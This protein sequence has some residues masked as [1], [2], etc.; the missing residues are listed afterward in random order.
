[1][2]TRS[3]SKKG[4]TLIELLVV[5]AIIGILASML[6][7][8][9]AKAKKKA[10]KMKSK[11]NLKQVQN[12]LF[13]WTTENGGYNPGYRNRTGDPGHSPGANWNNNFWKW[14]F[15]LD[16]HSMDFKPFFK[17]KVLPPV[18]LKR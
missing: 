2:K 17:K 9:L 15:C 16:S 5:I 4:F 6:L 12:A 11:N 7:P 3:Q 1:M 13:M 18:I 8:V 10:N 14:V